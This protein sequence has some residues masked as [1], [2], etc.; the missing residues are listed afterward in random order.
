MFAE[1]EMS[2][3]VLADRLIEA[4]VRAALKS[5]ASNVALGGAVDI[6]VTGGLVVLSGI[7]AQG[8]AIADLV[9]SIRQIDGVK[10]VNNR[11]RLVSTIYGV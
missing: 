3:A 2:R 1:S 11:V 4:R 6:A 5:V 9:T 7:V 8:G 10:D